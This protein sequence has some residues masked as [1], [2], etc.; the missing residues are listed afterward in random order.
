[1][2]KSQCLRETGESLRLGGRNNV[3]DRREVPPAVECTEKQAVYEVGLLGQSR[4]GVGKRAAPLDTGWL[5][6]CPL[7]QDVRF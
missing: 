2:S 6:S 7:L 4:V 1:M 3:L 5:E